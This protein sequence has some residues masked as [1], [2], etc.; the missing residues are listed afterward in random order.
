MKRLY[1]ALLFVAV[2]ANCCAWAQGG[3]STPPCGG[4][5]TTFTPQCPVG[6][7]YTNFAAQNLM[8]GTITDQQY[9]W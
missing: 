5:A 6:W 4:E 7:P 2:L 9:S 1:F 3:T 8:D